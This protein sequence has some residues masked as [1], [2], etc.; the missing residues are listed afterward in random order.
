MRFVVKA[1]FV[2]ILLLANT[3]AVNAAAD[4]AD[5]RAE[6]GAL[7][8][9]GQRLPLP[10][11][12]LRP[13]LTAHYVRNNGSIYWVGTGR[14][15]GLLQRM[16]AAGYDGLNPADYPA[17]ALAELRDDLDTDDAAAAAQA[18]LYYSAFFLAYAADLKIGRVSPQKVDPNLFRRPKTMD[19]LRALTDLK[20]QQDPGKFLSSFEPKNKH[21]QVLKRILRAY[22]TA[23]N[24]GIVWPVIEQGA[25]LKPGQRDARVLKVR[26]LLA[27][28]GDYEGNDE[29]SSAYDAELSVAVKKFQVRHGLEAKGLF[30]KQTI[31]AMNVPPEARRKQI[32]VNM[33]RWRWMPD[34]L[35]AEH[36]LVNIAAFE[37]QHVKGGQTVDRMNVVVGAV[38]TQTPEFSD[39]MEYLELNPYWNVPYNIATKEMLPKLQVN[40]MSYADEFDV[41]Y[42]GKLADWGR[43]DWSSYGSGK[44]PFTF[45]QKP[46]SK[47]ALGKV[48]FM[49]PNSH[50]IYL[51]DTPAKDKFANSTRAFSHGCI[52]LSRPVDLAYALLEQEVG[53]SSDEVDAIWESGEN[54]RIDFPRKI[55]VH[56]V[57]ATAFAT[58]NGIEF[59]T[60]V[61]GRDQK[62]YAA[63]FGRTGS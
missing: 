33:E 39:E 24:E 58:D 51:H 38:A 23:I 19:A 12:K 3:V 30:G 20:K 8:S 17:A 54:T 15:N 56:V 13:A 63:L 48:K 4:P 6:I 45:R 9:S 32:I 27:F 43:I 10:I 59:R 60:D 52:R 18:E 21:Y 41:F 16:G 22:V 42:N 35:G 40:A 61:Y 29:T 25:T 11:E 5:V 1:V 34:D 28:T 62:L 36:F 7:L 37:L 50:N 31:L 55:P 26:E 2:F 57:Y 44:F 49:L 46:G 14:M 47:N 53:M